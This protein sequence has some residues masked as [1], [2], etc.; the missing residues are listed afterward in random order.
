[1]KVPYFLQNT[2]LQVQM[3]DPAEDQVK[4]KRAQQ[5]ST[6]HRRRGRRSNQ[7]KQEKLQ[8][9]GLD[10]QLGSS[11]SCK[12]LVFA[13]RPGYGQL[14]TKCVVKANHFLADISASDLCHYNV[15]LIFR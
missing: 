12:S 4:S 3:K 1:M 8:E 6:D 9:R 2:T 7:S 11:A 15:S 5:N 14:G 10:S 13:A